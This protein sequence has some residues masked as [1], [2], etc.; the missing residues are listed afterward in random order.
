M[1]RKRRWA[2]RAATLALDS[3]R[4]L[5][6]DRRQPPKRDCSQDRER[7]TRSGGGI[8]PRASGAALPTSGVHATQHTKK[9]KP[10][11]ASRPPCVR[12]LRC[13]L[14]TATHIY[15]RMPRA[16]LGGGCETPGIKSR[17]SR[18]VEGSSK[19]FAFRGEEARASSPRIRLGGG[20]LK[21]TSLLG[22]IAPSFCL[23][24]APSLAA[25]SAKRRNACA[26]DECRMTIGHPGG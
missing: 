18:R 16:A 22:R 19:S 25:I 9:M 7:V 2:L 23:Q 5:K 4:S 6:K 12:N 1:R 10:T 15:F 8:A 13:F 20:D 14:R 17:R 26:A 24:A 11:A 3:A 21:N